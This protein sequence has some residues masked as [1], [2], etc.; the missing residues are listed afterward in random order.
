MGRGDATKHKSAELPDE[1]FVLEGVPTLGE[2]VFQIAA[3]ADIP[4][5]DDD[6]RYSRTEVG[7]TIRGLGGPVST[8]VL[9]KTLKP[10]LPDEDYE[11]HEKRLSGLIR[12]LNSRKKKDLIGF[13]V[14]DEWSVV[15]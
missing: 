3:K 13:V 5:E 6:E 4:K 1:P 7:D 10:A 2:L 14:G 11:A 12:D 15:S 9:A 8:M